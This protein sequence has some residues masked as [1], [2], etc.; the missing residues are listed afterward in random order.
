MHCSISILIHLLNQSFF[1]RIHFQSFIQ[2]KIRILRNKHH[3]ETF[4]IALD[5]TQSMTLA[6][7]LWEM[8]IHFVFFEILKQQN[9]IHTKVFA[10]ASRR[11]SIDFYSFGF[12]FILLTSIPNC[13][14]H[15]NVIHFLIGGFIWK[16]FSFKI[17]KISKLFFIFLLLSIS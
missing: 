3:E 14:A 11:R 7:N 15:F 1:R 16:F 6:Q 10:L 8:T 13:T 2:V 4:W 9:K 12:V 17:L 5:L